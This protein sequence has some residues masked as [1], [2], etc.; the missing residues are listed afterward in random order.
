MSYH[1]RTRDCLI[2]FVQAGN[3]GP[4]KIGRTSL[5]VRYRVR[6]LQ[7][8]CPYELLLLATMPGGLAKERALHARFRGDRLRGE[9]FRP[10]PELL[11]LIATLPQGS[12]V[13]A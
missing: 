10:S 5:V 2:Y 9:W 1:S 7:I 13:A 8:G 11:G 4:I 6:E 3:G 12:G